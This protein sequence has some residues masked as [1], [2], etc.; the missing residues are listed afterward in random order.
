MQVILCIK[1]WLKICMMLIIK[2]LFCLTCLHLF[3][4]LHKCLMFQRDR[5]ALDCA[6]ELKKHEVS[7][8]SLWPGYVRT[9]TMIQ[10][11]TNKEYPADI[12]HSV[13]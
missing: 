3:N 1:I 5:M 13:T 6:H 10:T 9:E 2:F 8:V 12:P 11:F 7:Y 4:V